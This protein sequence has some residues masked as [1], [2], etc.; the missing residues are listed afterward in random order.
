M[1]NAYHPGFDI[2]AYEHA[3]RS[4]LE[5]DV[6]T[7]TWQGHQFQQQFNAMSAAWQP[8]PPQMFAQY[9]DGL[10]RWIYYFQQAAGPAADWLAGA[11]RPAVRQRL[12]AVINDLILAVP[13]YRQMAGQQTA[14]PGART[15]AAAPPG[16]A[17]SGPAVPSSGAPFA[18]AGQ[19]DPAAA[20]AFAKAHREMA[21][22][23]AQSNR[24]VAALWKATNAERSA[25][26]DRISAARRSVL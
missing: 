18:A 12:A 13:R 3:I 2:D 20:A 9:A 8:M 19:A 10:E 4:R 6:A 5:A 7:L 26:H 15:W 11:G 23:L 14:Q 22:A 16:G 24:E 1:N 21:A 17:P 25:S